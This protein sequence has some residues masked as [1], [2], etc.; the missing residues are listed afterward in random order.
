MQKRRNLEFQDLRL[1][2]EIRLILKFLN[3]YIKQEK[4]G[5]ELKKN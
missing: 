4:N 5:A 2:V 1:L 3:K